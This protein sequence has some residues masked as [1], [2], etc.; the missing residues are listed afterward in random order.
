MTIPQLIRLLQVENGNSVSEDDDQDVS[1]L[2]DREYL[3]WNDDQQKHE[4]LSRGKTTIDAVCVA[5]GIY[6]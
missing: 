6:R 4:V 2:V 3:L 5:A 1:Y